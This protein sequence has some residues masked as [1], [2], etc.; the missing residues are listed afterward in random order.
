MPLA[1]LIKPLARASKVKL[2]KQLDMCRKALVLN[3]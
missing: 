2:S 1:T 3:S